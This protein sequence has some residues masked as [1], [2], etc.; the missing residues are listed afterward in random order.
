MKIEEKSLLVAAA[1]EMKLVYVNTGGAGYT[2]QRKGDSFIYYDTN[3]KRLRDKETLQRIKSL[4]I[5]PAWERVWISPKPN[6]HLQATGYDAAGRKQ[7]KYHN[8]WNKH[9]N[10]KKHSRMVEF[11]RSLPALRKRLNRDLRKK[12][13]S[14]EKVLALAITVMDKTCIRVG[15]SAYT[16]LYGSYGLTS[17]RNR[18]IQIQ[19][20][21]MTIAFKGKKG[22]YQ[23]IKLTHLR[24]SGMM[25]KLR[26]IPGQELFQYYDGNGEKRPVDSADINAYIMEGTGKDFTAKDFRTWWGTVSMF[27]ALA[28]LEPFETLTEARQNLNTAQ[29][30]VAKKLGNTKA[31]CKKYYI[32]PDVFTHYEEGRL[33]KYLE[34]VKR[35]RSESGAMN[36]SSPEEQVTMEYMRS[37]CRPR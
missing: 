6:G 35:L 11:A 18:H 12:E 28:E 15:N 27:S 17:L 37:E 25:K 3:G 1:R 22:V 30:V 34:K 14:R 29:E 7:Y 21:R 23:E 31:V 24:L 20:S 19:G 10:V 9:R 26:D 2:R 16:K 36:G 32:H 8:E 4:V 33:N 5:P 13:F